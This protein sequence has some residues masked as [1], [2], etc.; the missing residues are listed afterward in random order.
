MR[1]HCLTPHPSCERSAYDR[2]TMNCNSGAVFGT[3]LSARL[4]GI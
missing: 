4:G 1:V 3:E 2:Y